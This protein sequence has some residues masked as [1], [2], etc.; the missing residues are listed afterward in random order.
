MDN[1]IELPARASGQKR[2][3]GENVCGV[4]KPLRDLDLPTIIEMVECLRDAGDPLFLD[5]FNLNPREGRQ[6]AIPHEK[7]PGEAI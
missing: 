4:V 1:V 6:K 3:A 2:A 7:L 5:E